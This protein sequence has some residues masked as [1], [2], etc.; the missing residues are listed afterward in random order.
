MN[1]WRAVDYSAFENVGMWPR[2]EHAMPVD[3][4]QKADYYDSIYHSIAMVGINTSAMIEAAIVGRPVLAIAAPDFSDSHTGTYHFAYLTESTGGTVRTSPTIEAH[5]REIDRVLH[6][7]DAPERAAREFVRRFVRPH[8]L[9]RRA[10]DVFVD[11]I[12]RLPS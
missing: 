10:T 8:G 11:V 6:A 5:L 1:Q 9:D 4:E 3:R 12:E 7:G 2:D